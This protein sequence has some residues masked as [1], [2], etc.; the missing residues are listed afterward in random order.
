M[1]VPGSPKVPV[2]VIVLMKSASG[3]TFEATVEMTGATTKVV[4]VV[5]PSGVSTT[6]GVAIPFTK[7]ADSYQVW[8]PGAVG[9]SSAVTT[10]PSP[11]TS[12]AGVDADHGACGSRRTPHR[13]RRWTRGDRP[14]RRLTGAEA[15]GSR[16]GECSQASDVA[17]SRDRRGSDRESSR[18][19]VSQLWGISRRAALPRE[20]G[21]GAAGV[22][23]RQQTDCWPTVRRCY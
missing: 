8:H 4:S 22:V 7:S 14:L 2:R 12:R 15:S 3:P 6:V 20:R 19:A 9:K 10:V 11:E 18:W 5:T 16:E 23:P 17:A 1:V 13:H 21:R